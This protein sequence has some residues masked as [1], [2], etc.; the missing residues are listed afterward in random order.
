MVVGFEGDEQVCYVLTRNNIESIEKWKEA[1]T[2]DLKEQRV[3][4]NL[5]GRK[6]CS[7]VWKP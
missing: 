7:S 6:S 5:I 2:V 3:S 1:T 4:E